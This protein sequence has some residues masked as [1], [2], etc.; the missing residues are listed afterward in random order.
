MICKGSILSFCDIFLLIFIF[1][2]CKIDTWR[3]SGMINNLGEKISN[4]RI[5]QGLSQ[6]DLAEKL[7]AVGISVTNQKISKWETDYTIPNALQFIALCEVLNI[8]D[9]A[10]TFGNPNISSPLSML[11]DEG[12][13]KAAEYIDLLIASGK[14]KNVKENINFPTREIKLFDL[15][16]SAGVGEFLDSDSFELIEVGR[17]VPE[18]ADFGVR[19]CGNSMEPQFI[20]GQI[21]WIHKQDVLNDGEIGIFGLDN[22][23]YCKKL[24]ITTAS[25]KLISLNPNYSPIEIPKGVDL[26]VFGKVVG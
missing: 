18:E 26:H 2:R 21:V 8:N 3:C 5:K 1:L 22:K 25:T 11:N 16:V 12:K 10:G 17:E 13:K 4:L 24:S 9:V 6:Y 15:P 20:N 14:Y 23:A 19:I 7:S